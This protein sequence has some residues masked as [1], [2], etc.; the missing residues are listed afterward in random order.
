M[1]TNERSKVERDLKQRLK[2]PSV[3]QLSSSINE[4][5]AV[6]ST[7]RTSVHEP[8]SGTQKQTPS[9]MEKFLVSVDKN[10]QM[11]K[12][13]SPTISEEIATYAVLARK[14]VTTDASRFWKQHGNQMPLLT[15][16]A[17][18]YLSTPGTSVPSESA[19]SHSAYIGRKE[20]SRLSPENL[21]YT[22]FLK[23]K[24]RLVQ[25]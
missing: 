25:S 18:Y 19:F 22:I 10:L 11:N 16:Q 21:G 8:T 20:R 3:N 9:S 1:T 17:R 5:S 24:L 6:K 13:R 12:S 23:D 2:G 14:N 15:A 7:N 4:S